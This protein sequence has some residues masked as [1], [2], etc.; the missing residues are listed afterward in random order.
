M[1]LLFTATLFLCSPTKLILPPGER[2]MKEDFDT[3]AAA[4][5]SCPRHYPSSPCVRSVE[6]R[7]PLN[8]WVICGKPLKGK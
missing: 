6:R 3:L 7:S 2:P 5:K 4:K 8:Y 1:S